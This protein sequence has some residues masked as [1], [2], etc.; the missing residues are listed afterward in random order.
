MSEKGTVVCVLPLR[1]AEGAAFGE[2]LPS[3]EIEQ[4]GIVARLWLH[5]HIR[6][7]RSVREECHCSK[8]QVEYSWS[9]YMALSNPHLH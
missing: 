4:T 5:A 2:S 3:A 1:D 8:E 6:R 7:E 9:L